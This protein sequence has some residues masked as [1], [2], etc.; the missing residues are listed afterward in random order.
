LGLLWL[1]FYWVGQR[2][3][4]LQHLSEVPTLDPAFAGRTANEVLG[5]VLR[6]IADA[7]AYVL[8]SRDVGQF[9][10]PDL[11]A[12]TVSSPVRKS[13]ILTTPCGFLDFRSRAV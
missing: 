10:S 1:V 6:R 7:P 11:N 8:A 13:L 2:T 9:K 5:F 12:T 4:M 3:F